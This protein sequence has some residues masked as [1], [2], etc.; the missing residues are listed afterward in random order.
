MT[1]RALLPLLALGTLTACAQDGLELDTEAFSDSVVAEK[2]ANK[3]DVCHITGNG[4]INV[5]NVSV[6]SLN[7][8]LGHGDH[9]AGTF[10]LDSDGDGEGDA[11]T[12]SQCLDTGYVEN[13]DDC[14]DSD[15][16]TNTGAEEVCDDGI[17]NNCDGQV[18]EDCTVEVEIIANADNGLWAWIDGEPVTFDFNEPHWQIART[19]TVELDSGDHTFAFYV[20]DWGGL[21]YFAASIV[22][23]GQVTAVTGDG[24]FSSYRENTGY[25]NEWQDRIPYWTQVPETASDTPNLLIT[26]GTTWGDWM[27]TGFDDSSWAPD[28]NTCA[29]TNGWTPIFWEMQYFSTYY[30]GLFTDMYADGAETVTHYTGGWANQCNSGADNGQAWRIELSL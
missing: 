23:D 10:F 26:P 18:D 15:A 29:S 7:G 5:L 3:V 4:S 24:D 28:T 19:T 25:V 11:S 13:G 8:H 9:L 20:E 12:T 16:T 17:D 30:G 1:V 14:D 22:V 2:G 6:N 21:T 27:L